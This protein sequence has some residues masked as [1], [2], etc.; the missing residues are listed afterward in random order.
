MLHIQTAQGSA[1]TDLRR[2]GISLK[3][4]LPYID[5]QLISECKSERVIKISPYLPKLPQED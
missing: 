5:R 4:L 2:G 1:A 3:R